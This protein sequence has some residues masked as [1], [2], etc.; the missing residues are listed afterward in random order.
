VLGD[1]DPRTPGRKKGSVD[2]DITVRGPDAL[3]LSNGLPDLAPARQMPRARKT[4]A[5]RRRRTWTEVER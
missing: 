4:L 5:V 2:P 3:P 1:H